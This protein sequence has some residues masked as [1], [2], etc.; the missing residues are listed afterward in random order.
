[1][2]DWEDVWVVV[3]CR[4]GGVG[5]ASGDVTRLKFNDVTRWRHAE[6][7]CLSAR[8]V[9]TDIIFRP[10]SLKLRRQEWG[11]LNHINPFEMENVICVFNFYPYPVSVNESYTGRSFQN[12]THLCSN[13]SSVYKQSVNGMKNYSPTHWGNPLSGRE[14]I[15]VRTHLN[16]KFCIGNLYNH[17]HKQ[18]VF[19]NTIWNLL[20]RLETSKVKKSNLSFRNDILKLLISKII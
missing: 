2:N 19:W 7:L 16:P 1:M 12:L 14:T 13:S 9:S 5:V 17:V 10:L 20:S 6:T 18:P 11:K 8:V 15:F 4:V 3:E